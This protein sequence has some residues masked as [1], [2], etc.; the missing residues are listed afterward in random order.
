M[1]ERSESPRQ[2]STARRITWGAL[3][4]LAGAVLDC[5]ACALNHRLFDLPVTP[6]SLVVPFLVG[7]GAGLAIGLLFLVLRQRLR[8]L[9]VEST[10]LRRAE[11]SL[12]EYAQMVEATTDFMSFVDSDLIYRAVNQSYLAAYDKTREEIV[13]HSVAEIMDDDVFESSVKANLNRCLAGETVNYQARFD[14]AGSGR[15]CFDIAYHPYR[16]PSGSVSGVVV[17]ARDITSLRRTQQALAEKTTLLDN[18]L[19]SASDVAIV[20]TDLEFRI[21]FF[22]PMAERLFGSTSAE[23]VGKTAMELHPPGQLKPGQFERAI[24]NVRDQGEYRYSLTQETGDGQRHIESRIEGI[25]NPDGELV[26]YSLF[27]RDITERKRAEEAIRLRERY[28]AALN[29]VAET[30]LAPSDAVPFQE[31]VDRI[32]PAS[33]AGRV[34]VFMNHRRPDGGLTMSAVAEWCA[35]G[36][37]PEIGNPLL[38][39]MSVDEWLP[40]W[41]ENLHR[42][43]L[44]TGRVAIFPDKQRGILDSLGVLTIMHIPINIDTDFVGFVGFADCVSEREWEVTEQIFLRTA[45]SDLAQAIRR[46]RSQEQVRRYADQLEDLVDT[47]TTEIRLLERQRSEMEKLAATGRMAAGIAHE[48][49]NPLAGIKNAFELVKFGVPEDHKHYDF[50]GMIEKEIDRI[51]LIVSQMGLLYQPAAGMR[52]HRSLR[53]VLEDISRMFEARIRHRKLTLSVD[54]QDDLPDVR[55]VDNHLRQVVYNVLVNATQA[56]PVGSEVSV[57]CKEV[58]ETIQIEITDRGD[59]IAED[60]LPRIFEPFFTTKIEEDEGGMGLGLAVSD[61]MTRAM[62]GKLMVRTAVGEGTTFIIEFPIDGVNAPIQQE[63][64]NHD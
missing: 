59:G 19:S 7:G 35:E 40:R 21:T 34:Y 31:F 30:F 44:V 50:V 39:D 1:T 13:G 33:R 64:D 2:H 63:G 6:Q 8:K 41:R 51:A 28:L 56:A 54:I 37:T 38:Q 18:I 9:E 23:V 62:G 52:R 4:F 58:R 24:E 61:S 49:N 43:E 55:I 60:I 10:R 53:P 14:F 46:A 25:R 12:R 3:C 5:A 36:I 16:E 45:V 48:I 42:H 15:R 32:G 27:S 11:E 22:N 47:R 20:T 29:D 26:G 57:S 17:S